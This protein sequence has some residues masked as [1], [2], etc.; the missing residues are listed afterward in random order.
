MVLPN[1]PRDGG[2]IFISVS[3]LSSKITHSMPLNN[4]SPIKSKPTPFIVIIVD[5]SPCLGSKL[6]ILVTSTLS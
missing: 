6:D 2:K 4:I 3:I 5:P 1:S